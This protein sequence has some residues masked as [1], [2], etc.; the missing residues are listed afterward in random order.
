MKPFLGILLST[1]AVLAATSVDAADLPLK[2]KAI[3]YVKVCS[4][5]GAGFYYIPGSDTC[6]K[7]GGHIRVATTINGGTYD[8]PY[9]QSGAGASELRTKNYFNTRERFTFNVDTRTA[10]EY[11]VV[12]TFSAVLFDFLQGRENIS[13]GFAEVDYAF[14]QFAGFTFGKAIS[15]FDTQW[16]QAKPIIGGTGFMSGSNNL[17]GIAQLAYTAEFG[18]GWSGTIAVEDGSPYRQAGLYNTA[19][20]LIAPGQS[21]YLG[22]GY[23]GAVG[24]NTFLGNAT[25]GNHVPDIVGN[26]RLDQ[27]WGSLHFAAA[28]HQLTAANYGSTAAS[29]HP[30]DA[31]GYAVTM[32][33]DFKSLPTGAGDSLKVEASFANG[34]A[35]YIFGGTYDSAGAGRFAKFSGSGADQSLAFGYVLDGVFAP[36]G[37]IEKTNAWAVSAYYEHLWDP[38]WRTSIFGSYSK[39]EYSNDA[40]AL[41]FAAFGPGGRLGVNGN[42]N[43]GTNAGVLNATGDFSF[44]IAQIG[45]RT[46]WTPVKNLTFSAEFIYSR[47]EQNLTGTYTGAVAGRS[48]S[49]GQA[50]TY[51]AYTLKD[52]NAYNGTFQVLRSF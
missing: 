17:T 36:G 25:G 26:I 51:Q 34:A 18:N 45:T 42:G 33:L 50:A 30:D 19:N 1:A 27:A 7:L 49:A 9:I 39:I 6:V 2:A 15:N 16:V 35:K 41:L 37:S 10:T 46:S 38:A 47:I 21:T 28:G 22:S 3:E 32:G 14:L 31:W 52:Q 12:R 48:G 40:N 5:Y 23:G 24:T 20:F 43:T 4:L 44:G 29:G 13:G 11:G 8:L